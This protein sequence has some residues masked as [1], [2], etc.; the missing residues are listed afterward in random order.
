MK[1]EE[2]LALDCIRALLNEDYAKAQAAVGD[3]VNWSRF[4]RIYL[5]QASLI[6]FFY[7]SLNKVK[8]SIPKK[9]LSELK[10]AYLW[11]ETKTLRNYAE[12]GRILKHFEE[13]NIASMVL[14]GPV[15]NDLLY[16]RPIRFFNDIDILIEPDNY[17]K[18]AAVLTGLGFRLTEPDY[19]SK[20]E[21]QNEFYY[22]KDNYYIV[23]L[24]LDIFNSRQ[25]HAYFYRRGP[26]PVSDLFA[27]SSNVAVNG[28]S[29][30]VMPATE[31]LIYTCLHHFAVHH[32][33]NWR[34]FIDIHQIIEKMS[35]KIDWRKL[36]KF[37]AERDIKTCL[38]F[39]L[40]QTKNHLNSDIPEEVL[41]ELKPRYLLARAFNF[42]L[43]RRPIFSPPHRFAR[44]LR[45]R[46]RDRLVEIVR[47]VFPDIEWFLNRYQFLPKIKRPFLYY[48]FYPLLWLIVILQS[49]FGLLAKRAGEV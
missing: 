28:H 33:K 22:S 49:I 23:D 11:S 1:R 17:A 25:K 44:L 19:P 14:K 29:T 34:G 39:S 35:S 38:Y 18:A 8:Q 2:Q 9:I 27:A 21:K 16:P 4:R 5:K 36:T 46:F 42:E 45:D 7:L 20:K 41:N 15:F 40:A 12:L 10:A 47:L 24:H 43:K 3:D 32:L 37:A 48:P 31:L 30:L 13:K 6:P 26:Y